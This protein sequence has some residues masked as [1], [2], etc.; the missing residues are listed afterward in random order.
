MHLQ[1]WAICLDCAHM[2]RRRNGAVKP[3][4]PAKAVSNA[5]RVDSG[6]PLLLGITLGTLFS[7]FRVVAEGGE[8]ANHLTSRV[9][10]EDEGVLV[11]T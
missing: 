6:W 11:G 10:A 5:S 3:P 4:A 2:L 1:E 8:P 9:D 7:N